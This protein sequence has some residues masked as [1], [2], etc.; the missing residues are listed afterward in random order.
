MSDPANPADYHLK[1]DEQV[2][3]LLD[4]DHKLTFFIITA[5][6]AS[7]GFTL[8]FAVSNELPLLG[9]HLY[10]LVTF[11]L[12]ATSSLAAAGVALMCLQ[13]SN[14]SFRLHVRYRY[15]RREF[16]DLSREEQSAWHSIN[17]RTS[18]FRRLAFIA[19]FAGVALQVGFA[20]LGLIQREGEGMHHYGEDSTEVVSTEEAFEILFKN[21]ETGQKI[22]MRIP[23]IGVL[24]SPTQQLTI[25]MVRTL[26]DEIAHLLRQR[27]N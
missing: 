9:E 15:S 17:R 6:V 24:E 10:S 4:L 11:A 21:K 1:I 19:L 26:A 8:D 23:R 12:A 25:K 13:A 18:R 7:L 20:S 3:K 22:T 16:A 27:M 2:N 5:A 14:E